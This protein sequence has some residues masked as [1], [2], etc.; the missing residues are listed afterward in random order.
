MKKFFLMLGVVVL[1]LIVVV[2]A[3]V[4]MNRGKLANM[5]VEKSLPQVENLI[6]DNLPASVSKAQLHQEFEKFTA[7]VK[8]G[9]IDAQEIQKM[10]MNFKNAM[11]D[12]KLDSL[13]VKSLLESLHKLSQ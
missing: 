4:Y 3:Y 10:F 12:K 11:E 2:F 1:V 6:A 9:K 5:M 8:A 13:E 7:N